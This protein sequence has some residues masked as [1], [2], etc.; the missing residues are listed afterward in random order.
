M[1]L[2]IKNRLSVI[3]TSSGQCQRRVC[4]SSCRMAAAVCRYCCCRAA[5]PCWTIARLCARRRRRCCCCVLLLLVLLSLSYVHVPKVFL[6]VLIYAA[7]VGFSH[8]LMFPILSPKG[9]FACHSFIDSQMSLLICA[10]FCVFC[11]L[12]C[13]FFCSH[14]PRSLQS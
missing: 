12:F 6:F 13:V 14:V 2:K 1:F 8:Y 7:C 4:S 3:M 11:R 5:I 10:V 9:F